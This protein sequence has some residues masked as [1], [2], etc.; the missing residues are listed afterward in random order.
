MRSENEV[1]DCLVFCGEGAWPEL[2]HLGGLLV[3]AVLLVWF[4]EMGVACYLSVVDGL[5]QMSWN[6]RKVFL[7]YLAL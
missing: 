4:G 2:R 6:W 1:G 7:F 3:G 5:E